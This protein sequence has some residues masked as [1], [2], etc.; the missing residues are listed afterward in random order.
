MDE[1]ITILQIE[2]DRLRKSEL[3]LE[4]LNAVGVDN[5]EGYSEA[6]RLFE[7]DGHGEKDAQ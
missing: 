1:K 5:W 4:Y 2:Y 7:E 3:F 6:C